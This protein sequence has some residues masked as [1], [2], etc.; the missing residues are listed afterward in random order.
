MAIVQS[1]PQS[2]APHAD[3]ANSLVIEE[4]GGQERTL[5]LRGSGLPFHGVG[6]GG[7]NKVTTTWYNGNP[8]GS[9][10]VLGPR[11][12]P[13]DM[14]GEWKTTLLGRTPAVISASGGANTVIR[15]PDS[16]RL[17][18]ESFR[19]S[20]M[21]LK[22]SWRNMTREGRLVEFT[23]TN[24]YSTDVHWKAKFDWASVG[25]DA[26]KRILTT[27][28]QNQ[29]QRYNELALSADAIAN[30]D[31]NRT[32]AIN[33]PDR[34]PNGAPNLTLGQISNFLNAPLKLTQS[35]CRQA[36]RFGKTMQEIGGIVQQVQSLGD[37]IR[38]TITN[39]AKNMSAIADD[40][41]KKITRQS[42]EQQ[43]RT[44][45]VAN[46]LTTT[47]YFH[48]LVRSSQDISEKAQNVR[49]IY[50]NYRAAS[51]N[52]SNVGD[53][54]GQNRVIQ[55]HEVKSGE[56]LQTIS[57]KYYGNPDHSFDIAISNGISYP[58]VY[59]GRT[60]SGHR[61]LIIPYLEK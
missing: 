50:R 25:L 44:R 55:I 45:T 42:P 17:I 30:M 20:G 39:E 51:Q 47:T 38:A 34:L 33:K 57:T 29:N 27:R 49:D 4:L 3:T 41:S 60:I 58:A 28:K 24:G 35:L 54:A 19:D 1:K 22:V 6:W 21:R 5:T 13:T 59:D 26:N 11:L 36:R 37:N 52:T 16:L 43:T 48:T 61:T 9:Q 10:Q 2:L 31:P 15:N 46:L 7:E 56:T 23:P 14:E 12:L 32:Y 8:E 40:F 53:S 18:F